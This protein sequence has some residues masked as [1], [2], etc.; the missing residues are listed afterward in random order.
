LGA[1]RL[2]SHECVLVIPRNCEEARQNTRKNGELMACVKTRLD[3]T[4]V[5]RPNRLTF[6]KE[7]QKAHNRQSLGTYVWLTEPCAVRQVVKREPEQNICNRQLSQ[8]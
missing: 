3:A 4:L 7:Q 6:R 2:I 8:L 1:I 5:T